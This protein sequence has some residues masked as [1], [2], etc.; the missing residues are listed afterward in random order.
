MPQDRL[1]RIEA[2]FDQALRVPKVEREAFLLH[3]CAGDADVHREVIELLSFARRDGFS[4]SEAVAA[5]ASALV[6]DP[7]TLQIGR[8]IGRFRLL[9]LLGQ[10]GMGAVYV[11][12]REDAEFR[13]RVAIKLMP[14]ALGTPLAIA[15]FRDERQILAALEHA[16]IVRLLDGG[17][18]EDGLP[19]LVMEHIAGATITQH[20]AA[21]KLSLRARVGLVRDVCAALQYA[22]QNLVIH[23][24]IK[25]SNILVDSDG[26]PKVLDFG[27]ATLIAPGPDFEREARTRTGSRL[28]TPAYASPE[29]VRGDPVST[30]TDVY[31]VGAVLYELVTGVAP[32]R[33]SAGPL[34]SLRL[35]C[36]VDP[37]RP[38]DVAPAERRRE[39]SGDLDNIIL[40]ALHKE[41][42]RRYA[43]ME[44]LSDDLG[45][46]LEGRP[47][48][49]RTATI[50]YRARKFA[51][52]NKV[53]VIAASVVVAT[54]IGGTGVSL[55]QARRADVEAAQA[56]LEKANAIEAATRARIE[57]EHARNAEAQVQA[58]LD[59]IRAEQAARTRA[60]AEARVHRNEAELSREQLQVAL[61]RA[62]ED[63]QLA[64]QE[65][66]RAREAEARAEAAARAEKAAREE[67]EALYQQERAR[68]QHLEEQSRKITNELR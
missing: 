16:N 60:E 25:P 65:S 17:S 37:P 28:F 32:H 21:R 45:R 9:G 2:L 39:L 42:A 27:I 22:H 6:G 58:Q 34:E 29:Q 53:A 31:S 12:Q 13:Q 18:T 26:V 1:Q 52:R 64:E 11:A 57:A 30:A 23:R 3:A 67:K 40:K 15:R 41:P 38:S 33:A 62:R 48:T 5:A 59:Q 43:S 19:Y 14:H 66:A 63:K 68:R 10:G 20:A 8:R 46:F 36:E 54:M 56:L 24:D 44:Q 51:Q 47:V 50:G 61:A 55:W 4:L 49:A 7:V 35:I